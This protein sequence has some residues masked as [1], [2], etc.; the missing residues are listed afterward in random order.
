MNKELRVWTEE[1][2]AGKTPA[3]LQSL[4][5]A[6]KT[7]DVLTTEEKG[8]NVIFLESKINGVDMRN[9]EVLKDIEAGASDISDMGGN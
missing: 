1:K 9:A 8:L 6:V 2:V 3:E 5:D 7:S 4:L